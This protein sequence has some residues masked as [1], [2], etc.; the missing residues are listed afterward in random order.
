MKISEARKACSCLAACNEFEYKILYNSNEELGSED[1]TE[2]TVSMQDLP[3]YRYFRRLMKSDVDIFIAIG[4]IFGFYF[5]LSLI[6]VLEIIWKFLVYFY[7]TTRKIAPPKG[8]KKDDLKPAIK[9][10]A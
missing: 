6:G 1:G 9:T 8:E 10:I 5:G 4:G 7:K 3:T 2:I